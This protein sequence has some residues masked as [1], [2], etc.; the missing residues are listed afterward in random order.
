MEISYVDKF[1]EIVSQFIHDLKK[2]CPENKDLFK[3]E[4][5]ITIICTHSRKKVI[6]AKF[7]ANVL[8]DE[9]VKNILSKNT[10]FFINYKFVNDIDSN[11]SIINR[12]QNIVKD[13]NEKK[14][15]QSI[16]C[17][18]NWVTLMVYFAY[19]DLGI[20]ADDKFKKL[21]QSY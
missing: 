19:K 18:F 10:D 13:L 12:A 2:I 11:V 4:Q 3:I 16:E 15:L 8:R 17:V 20:D 14:D 5:L 6:I 21:V 9:F 1:N 7:Q